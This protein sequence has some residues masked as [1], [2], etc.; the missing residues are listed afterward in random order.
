MSFLKESDVRRAARNDRRVLMKS[1]DSAAV[2]KE[3]VLAAKETERFDIFLCHS[4]RDAEIVQGAKKILEDHGLSIYVDWIVDPYMDRAAVTADTAR[5]LR[6]RMRQASSLLYLYS[7]NATRSRWMPW[8]LGFFDGINGSVGVLPVESDF[9]EIDFSKEE[10][11]GLY[12]KVEVSDRGIFV[13][14]TKGRPVPASEK[15]NWMP[16]PSWISGTEKLRL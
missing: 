16:F 5:I 12:P 4:I 6:G 14:R 1:M 15:N 10:F 9:G 3:S 11:L 8:E 2:L 13:N 7:G